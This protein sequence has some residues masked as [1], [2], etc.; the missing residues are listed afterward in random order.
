MVKVS[1]AINA[2]GTSVKMAA[3]DRPATVSGNTITWKSGFF[4]EITWTLTPQG[5]GSTALVTSKSGL[6]VNG[7]ATF[8][9]TQQL[10]TSPP[11]PKLAATTT[12][13]TPPP[14]LPRAK[15]VSD[16]PGFVYNPFDPTGKDVFDVRNK[17]HGATVRDPASGKLFVLP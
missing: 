15:P 7:T 5:G 14:D 4:N 12:T 1:L 9:R 11:P 3:G 13:S 10:V 17:A 2:D 6:G 16:K 8:V